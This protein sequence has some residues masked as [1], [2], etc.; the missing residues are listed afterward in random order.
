[1]HAETELRQ[2][3][4][5]PN[6]L[7]PIGA[8]LLA[9]LVGFVF[10]SMLGF[11]FVDLDVPEQLI[12]N[13]Y[14]HGLSLE[15][16]KHILT[17]RCSRSYYPL[18]ALTFAADY[19]IWG[20][21]PLGFKLTNGLIHLANVLLIF[22]LILR[23][24]RQ[25]GAPGMSVGPRWDVVPAALAAAVFAVHPLAVE[26]VAWVAGREELLMTLATLGAIHFHL[27]ARNRE[28]RGA[29]E[30]RVVA[31]HIGT[32]CCCAAACLSN[33]VGVV[34]PLLITAWDLLA[35]PR[36]RTRKIL[37]AT[38]PLWAIA[39]ATVAVKLS[40]DAGNT[41][42]APPTFSV[43]RLILVLNIFWL[44]ITS[45]LWPRELAVHYA[46]PTPEGFLD[47]GVILGGVAL[48]LTLVVLGG[49][50][51]RKQHLLLFGLCWFGLSLGPVSGILTYHLSRTDRFLYLPL[52]GLAI[53]LAAGLR[54]CGSRPLASRLVAS[55]SLLLVLAAAYRSMDQLQTWQNSLTLWQNALKIDPDNSFARACYAHTLASRK[56][57]PQ[58]IAQYEEVLR[59]PPVRPEALA[60][61]ARVL[62]T[63]DTP[64]L[65]NY[66]RASQL[67]E[68]ACTATEWK[69]RE[70]LHRFA[71][72]HC[73][74]AE[75]LAAQGQVKEAVRH[76]AMSIEADP[77]FDVPLFNL[78]LLLITSPDAQFRQPGMAVELAERGCNLPTPPDAHKLAILAV[79]YSQTKRFGDAIAT[80]LEA[81]EMARREGDQ[82]MVEELEYQLGF[83][84]NGTAFG[85]ES[86]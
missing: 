15:N 73:A 25:S 37:C 34:V 59:R 33:A 75:D 18:R 77:D 30:T 60:E 6:R 16:V 65:R 80:V 84:R 70:I 19:E 17:S 49:L 62:A 51:R 36:P 22:W 2:F 83:Y 39:A 12:E 35:V 67:A 14:V 56:E 54:P 32:T 23:L 41:A 66:D 71:Q 46:W 79:A 72:V 58:A 82:E 42:G 10:H 76:Y 64:E 7:A 20:L 8:G 1:M 28:Q 5:L 4:R 29:K 44:N 13:E 31:S 57:F 43:G 21:N 48:A 47:R 11:E 55:V 50:W 61:F 81:I 85:A 52:V 26:P 9:L 38:A 78:A 27:T 86:E 53:A 3:P 63:C 24:F 40:G 69:D 74:F 68:W 45:L